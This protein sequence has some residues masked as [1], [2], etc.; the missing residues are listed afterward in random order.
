MALP[1]L[2]LVL[3]VIVDRI[4]GDPHSRFHPVALLGS[5]ISIWGKPCL[6][7]EY[8]QRFSGVILALFTA[9]LF[10]TPFYLFERYAPL[11]VFVVGAPFFLKA[12]FAWR[13]LEEHVKSVENAFMTGGGRNEVQM[14]VSRDACVLND[15]EI[16]SA[17]YESMAENLVDSVVSP[18]FYFTFF[19]LLGA[20]FFR[21]FNTMDAMLGYMDERIRLG[22]FSARTDDVL[23]YVPARFTGLILVLYFAVRGNLSFA[24][25]TF[26]RD[27]KKRGGFNGGIPMSLIAG[28]C[29]TAF[30]KPGVYVIGEG[31]RSLFDARGDILSAFRWTAGISAVIF[32]CILM[33]SGEVLFSIIYTF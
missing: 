8:L 21:A 29:R 3:S 31:E 30:V 2:I 7:P 13:S 20:A 27:R 26:L 32:A 23:N 4:T 1:A 33:V 22:W 18:L 24:W 19:G 25:R 28:G 11:V 10:S 17:A 9:L 15:E 14:L 6:Y 16:L 5:F 12:C